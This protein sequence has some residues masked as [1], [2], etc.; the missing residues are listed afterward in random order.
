MSTVGSRIEIIEFG[1]KLKV[2]DNQRGLF[3]ILVSLSR[4]RKFCLKRLS[5]TL[6]HDMVS[7]V[8]TGL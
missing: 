2:Q 8:A 4:Q 1:G 3:P 7:R 6:C 5:L